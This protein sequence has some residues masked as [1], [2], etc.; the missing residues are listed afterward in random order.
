[1]G[2]VANQL[3]AWG[4][5]FGPQWMGLTPQIK[6]WCD[7]ERDLQVSFTIGPGV[8]F[9]GPTSLVVSIES[10]ADVVW[11]F[12]EYVCTSPNV[13]AQAP[14]LRVRVRDGE[15]R[16][17]TPEYVDVLDVI[18]TLPVPLGARATTQII[19]DLM[20][21][22]TVTI[23]GQFILKCVKRSP[24]PGNNP[25]KVDYAPLYQRY[26]VAPPGFHDEAATYYYEI[27][28]A[29]AGSVRQIPLVINNDADFMWRAL[30]GDGSRGVFTITLYD[31]DAVQMC[32]VATPYENLTGGV[33]GSHSTRWPEISVPAGGVACFVDA[34]NLTNSAKTLKLALRGCKRFRV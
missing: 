14:D 22:G 11:G 7:I 19:F 9:E 24:C 15:G 5:L 4:N 33:A 20:N 25:L 16:L 23:A 10:D 13:G 8:T 34:F 18:G 27:A 21:L 12:W 28:L 31:S 1:M 17:L 30:A 6:D 26:S 29:A 2:S 32:N 3:P